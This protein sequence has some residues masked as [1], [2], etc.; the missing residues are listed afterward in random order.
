MSRSTSDEFEIEV[1][2]P[3]LAEEYLAGLHRSFEGWG[4]IETYRWAFERTV[5]GPPAD[6]MLLRL[7][8]QLAAGSAVSYRLL[9]LASGAMTLAGIM[10]GS[11]TLPEARGRGA[12]TR[13]IGESVRLASEQRAGLL[14]AFVTSDNPSARRLAAAGSA[15]FPTFYLVST[16]E[17]GVPPAAVVA[18]SVEDLEGTAERLMG[19]RAEEQA[20]S[21]HFQ[22]P[23]QAV[24]ESQ[25]LRRPGSIEVLSFDDSAWAVVE[26]VSGTDRVHLL[27]VDP[28]G[29]LDAADCLAAL[30]R[31]AI[32]RSRK[33]FLFTTRL[34]VHE[35]CRSL[36][37]LV[38]PGFLTALVADEASLREAASAPSGP[39]S[40]EALSDPGSPWFLGGWDLQSGDR[41]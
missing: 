36:G 24:W 30:L 18:E 41:T 29:G 27:A 14:L 28:R 26:A 15:V 5:G 32:E 17:T 13:V 16:A 10:T 21:C 6:R 3:G 22:Y 20:G 8:G 33:L 4:G 25:F 40:A 37:L 11:W 1:N 39:A 38:K 12:F 34:D 9:R 23:D 19:L 31:R 7:D 35:A 2:P